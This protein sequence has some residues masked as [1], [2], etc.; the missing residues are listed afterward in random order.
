MEKNACEAASCKIL[1]SNSNH[2]FLARKMGSTLHL[3][4][5]VLMD[6][7]FNPCMSFVSDP[8]LCS[9]CDAEPPFLIACFCILNIMIIVLRLQTSYI[10]LESKHQL[11][12]SK[13][14]PAA[15]APPWW[16][17]TALF[18]ANPQSLRSA[19]HCVYFRCRYPTEAQRSRL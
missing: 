2:H 11:Y 9:S 7:T 4:W 10:P 18:P 13:P 14:T 6:A 16:A 19:C 1:L 17:R 3:P 5:Q 12:P 15:Q 8:M